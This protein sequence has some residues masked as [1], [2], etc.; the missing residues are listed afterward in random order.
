[1]KVSDVR[2]NLN[3]FQRKY[4]NFAFTIPHFALFYVL[5]GFRR[6]NDKL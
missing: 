4:H 1:M 5:I 6:K 2:M 3:D